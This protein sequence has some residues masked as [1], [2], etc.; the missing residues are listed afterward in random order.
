MKR[1]VYL[2]L[3]L[4]LYASCSLAAGTS[5][6]TKL[7]K[8]VDENGETHYGSVIP[9]EYADRDRTMLDGK[10]RTI[11]SKQKNAASSAGK[12][13]TDEETVEQRRK[14]MALLNT[15][16][17]VKEIDLAQKRN[18]QQVEARI[19][20]IEMQ[21]KS[22][23]TSLKEL[24]KERAP[25]IKAQKPVPDS[26]KSDIDDAAARKAKLEDSLKEARE[27]EA[28]VKETYEGY[29]KRYIELTSGATE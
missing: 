1:T 27:K 7:Y 2:G 9:P 14:D 29:K 4:M 11:T 24:Q 23:E 28:A 17:N 6:G 21:L 5:S 13:S 12:T 25:L 8:W 19:E 20:S 15:Y 22:V 26:L 16:S 3:A 10:G 18:L